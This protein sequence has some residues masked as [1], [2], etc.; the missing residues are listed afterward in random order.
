MRQPAVRANARGGMHRHACDRPQMHGACAH[1]VG[2]RRGAAKSEPTA[3]GAAAVREARGL[4]EAKAALVWGWAAEGPAAAGAG[5]EP[6]VVE[7]EASPPT[8][9]KVRNAA[10]MMSVW[11]SAFVCIYVC[12]GEGTAT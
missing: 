12:G 10:S 3:A 11:R 7:A 5:W 1:P 8:L 2:W 4:A 9:L 6:A